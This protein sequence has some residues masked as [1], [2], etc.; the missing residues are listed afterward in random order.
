MWWLVQ[1]SSAPLPFDVYVS[2][3]LNMYYSWG[4][5]QKYQQFEYLKIDWFS[6]Q[7]A[8]K[9]I[10]RTV[11]RKWIDRHWTCTSLRVLHANPPKFNVMSWASWSIWQHI[12][13]FMF[14]FEKGSSR[15]LLTFSLVTFVKLIDTLHKAPADTVDTFHNNNVVFSSFSSS[16]SSSSSSTSRILENPFKC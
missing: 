5:S 3:Q 8:E 14:C 11:R 9:L 6:M 15:L 10:R 4:W 7:L 1:H 13:A 12:W 16:S 2:N